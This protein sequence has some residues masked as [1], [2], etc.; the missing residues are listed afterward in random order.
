MNKKGYEFVGWYIDPECTKRIN[1]GGILPR[2]TTLYDKWIPSWYPIRY[3]MHGGINSRKNPKYVTCEAP[4]LELYPPTYPGKIFEGWYYQGEP[5]YAIPAG[6]TEA[7]NIEARFSDPCEVRFETYGG[8]RIDPKHINTDRYLEPFP[9]PMRMGHAFAG[10]YWDEEYRF[11]FSFDQKIY[12][13][14]TL[15]AKWTADVFT[16]QY[17]LDGG[18]NA[19]SNPSRYTMN[20]NITLKPAWKPGF[21]FK[22][23]VNQWHRPVKE[24]GGN[25]QGDLVLTAIFEPKE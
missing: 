13:D 7:M 20:Q 16:I 25:V 4:E 17:H 8:G 12:N 14:C 6:T 9:H 10:W 11:P 15:Y 5:I 24:L 3:E 22:G 23:W 2:V 1:P 18:Y 21:T 19:R